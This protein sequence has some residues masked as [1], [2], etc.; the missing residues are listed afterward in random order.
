MLVKP[1]SG[2]GKATGKNRPLSVIHLNRVWH[3]NLVP[4]GSRVTKVRA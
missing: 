4:V 2:A 3:A 1:A